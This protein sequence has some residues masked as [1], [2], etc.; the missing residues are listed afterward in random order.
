MTVCIL[1]WLA[2]DIQCVLKTHHKKCHSTVYTQLLQTFCEHM[3]YLRLTITTERIQASQEK[4]PQDVIPIN[5]V[6]MT[7][8]SDYVKYN[9]Q[10]ATSDSSLS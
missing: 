1:T 9:S 3:D 2:S 7:I 4:S 10:Q 8:I 5:K 6:W